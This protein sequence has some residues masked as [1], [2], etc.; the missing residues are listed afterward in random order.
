MV[1]KARRAQ[2]GFTYIEVMV[3]LSVVGVLTLLIVQALAD[4]SKSQSFTRGQARIAEVSDRIMRG[5]VRD[6]TF[7]VRLFGDGVDSDDYLDALAWPSSEALPDAR[8]PTATDLGYFDAD[9]SGKLYTGNTLFLGRF[10]SS[11]MVNV[12]MPA[13]GG[14]TAPQ[15]LRVD[16][17]GLIIYYLRV[18]EDGV[19]DLERWGSVPVALYQ[20]LM[21]IED[22]VER[23]SAGIQLL[24]NGVSY[25]WDTGETAANGLYELT[26]TG[27]MSLL[28]SSSKIPGDPAQIQR[29]IVGSRHVRV[30]R[31]GEPGRIKVPLYAEAGSTGFPGGF[32][33]KVDGLSTG[34]LTLVRM[35]LRAGNGDYGDNFAEVERVV[36]CRDG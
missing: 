25:V 12:S 1:V 7:S 4:L 5:V 26:S 23:A 13:A 15:D 31:N 16:T 18:N 8:L 22:V 24:A 3:V 35:A 20:D 34:K 36:S 10:Q 29:S 28:P 32:E 2:R 30:A 27:Q 9:P 21:V 11:V 6:L 33:I 14:G 19:L 17:L